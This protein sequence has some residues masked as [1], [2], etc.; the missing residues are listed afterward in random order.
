MIMYM[1]KPYLCSEYEKHYSMKSFITA[2]TDVIA[3]MAEAAAEKLIIVKYA[4]SN[5]AWLSGGRGKIE[6]FVI[7][8]REGKLI[9][10]SRP[11][12][13]KIKKP[14]NWKGRWNYFKDYL[15]LTRTINYD[16]E[17]LYEKKV[18]GKTYYNLLLSQIS[19]LWTGGPTPAPYHFSPGTADVIIG[20]GTMADAR[21]VIFTASAGGH[22]LINW[23]TAVLHSN[24]HADD[25]LQVMLIAGDGSSGIWLPQCAPPET[26]IC[27]ADGITGFDWKVP[28]TFLKSI[29]CEVYCSIK[30]RT[31]TELME[32][33]TGNFRFTAGMMPVTLIP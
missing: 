12:Q 21:G 27:R 20:N 2:L 9:I 30:F 22:L 3:F 1:N 25:V 7:Y 31:G 11:K 17:R 33:V 16:L 10:R 6:G 32:R 29:P 23:D 28:S 26:G 15:K 24:E 5:N 19:K 8:S 18:E 13:Y 4:I 14:K